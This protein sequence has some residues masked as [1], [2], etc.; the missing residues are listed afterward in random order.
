MLVRDAE[1][2]FGADHPFRLNAADHARLERLDLRRRAV[3][4]AVEEAS[5]GERKHNLLPSRNVRCTGDDGQ[6]MIA[7]LDV[8]QD[9]P[10]RVGVLLDVA[11]FGDED[12]VAPHLA[13]LRD[14]LGLETCHGEAV[15][16]F[17]CAEI[18]LS[19]LS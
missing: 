6:A 7:G 19:E 2:L 11:D 5:A 4:V 3:R 15:G 17:L 10:V 1:L 12:L 8:G 18:R 13:D 9:Q 16:Q 14:L